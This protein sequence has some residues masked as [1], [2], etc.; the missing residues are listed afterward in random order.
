MVELVMSSVRLAKMPPP[1][2]I[3]PLPEMVELLMVRV[4]VFSMPPPLP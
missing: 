2:S 1:Y 4:P 3:E